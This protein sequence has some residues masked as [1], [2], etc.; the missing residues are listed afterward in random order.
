LI[1]V[2]A[3]VT[4]YRPAWHAG[5]IWDD[6]DYVVKNE[7]LTAPDGLKR[8]WFSLDS[9]SQ[10]FPLTY[11]T[12][13]IERRV[14]GLNPT[15]YH[16]VNILLHSLNALLIWRLLLRLGVPGAWL[17]AGLFALHPVQVESVAWITE[18][19]NV[20]SLCFCLLALLSWAGFI[21]ERSRRRWSLYAFTLVFH[22]LALFSKTTACTLPAAL[23]LVLWLKKMPITR[24][25]LAQVIP[26]LAMGLGMGLVTIWWE[27]FHQGTQGKLFSV[28][29]MERLLIA[30]RALWFYAGKLA[31]PR[32]LT[33]SYPHWTMHAT[34]PLA[35]SWLAAGLGMCAVIYIARRY[36]GRGL[37][38]AALYYAT[39]LSPTLGF[40]MLYTFVWSFVADHYQYMASIG[41]LALGAAAITSGLDRWMKGKWLFQAGVCGT[42][43][44]VLGTLTWRQSGTYS[45]LQTVWRTTLARNPDSWLA[46]YN[47]GSE[48]SKKN[49]VQEAIAHFQKAVVLNPDFVMAQYN[50]GTL[51]LHDGQVDAAMARL[52][53]TLEIEPDHP[54][55]H[56]KLGEALMRKGRIDE[57]IIHYQT[58]LEVYTNFADAFSNL[59]Y[60]YLQEGR[61]DEAMA[62]YEKALELQPN[63]VKDHIN[64]GNALLQKGRQREAMAQFQKVLEIEPHYMLADNNLAWVLATS[65]D[66]SLRNGI[67]AVELAEEAERLSG[68]QNPIIMATLAAAYAEAGR[69]PD[70]VATIQRALQT[71]TTQNNTPLVDALQ[72]QLRLYEAGSPFRAPVQQESP[73]RPARP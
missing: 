39:T 4:S 3:T 37:E 59:G 32:N 26:F 33:F 54:L 8:I 60:A 72:M 57:A 63:D 9:P 56:N 15:G 38:V 51:L 58:A 67:K 35:Y 47:L 62:Q 36:V 61:A 68:N 52:E 45:D 53:K 13:R 16:C 12:F 22:A 41:P 66:A 48:L 28:G 19:K 42:L 49:Q 25:R 24:A 43:L 6:D 30:S 44:L 71:A 21:Q 23:L 69:F 5:F 70:A 17:A 11:T 31:W 65:P 7:L 20:L 73:S 50:L 18:R 55:A 14:W 10:Y 1:L 29:W 40:I 27:R 64:L 46:H 34:D 2:A